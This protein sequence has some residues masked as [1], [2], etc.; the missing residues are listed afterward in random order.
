MATE[1]KD[2]IIG[3]SDKQGATNSVIDMG[4]IELNQKRLMISL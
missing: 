3:K 2:S 4:G 1:N